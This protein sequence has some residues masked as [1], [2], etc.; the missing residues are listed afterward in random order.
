MRRKLLLSRQQCYNVIIPICC[1]V[2]RAPCCQ[3]VSCTVLP[4]CVV[5]RAPCVVY[6][7]PC[8]QR[9][10]CTVHRVASM[11]RLPYTV[12]P[13][14]VVYRAPPSCHNMS[15][16]VNCV[17]IMCLYRAPCSQ[18]VSCTVHRVASMHCVVPNYLHAL[19][20]AVLPACTVSCRGR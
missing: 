14:C 9:V 16:T 1:A 7:S 5:Y 3:H 11:C 4:A 2:Y 12:L 8:Y 20:R 13:E 15:C 17:A 19:C 10:S 6:R 18:I